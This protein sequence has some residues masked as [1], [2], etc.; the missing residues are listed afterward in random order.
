MDTELTVLH[1]YKD[2]F[3][4]LFR[5]AKKITSCLNIGDILEILRDEVKVTIP[6]AQEAC[7]IL[8]DSEAADYT[9]PL[10]CSV[11]KEQVNCQ[12]CKRGRAIVQKAMGEPLAFQCMLHDDTLG[13]MEFSGAC[14]PM[15]EVAIPIY[16][17]SEP[18]AV[19]NVV[20]ATGR[21][22]DEKDM[23]LLTDLVE[24]AG[25]IIINAKRY[26]KMAR[27]KLT[28]ERILG[29]IRTFVPDTVQ[30]IVEKNPDA[31]LLEK[32]EVDVSILFLDVADYTR[33]S[34]TLTQDKVNFIIEKYFSSFLDVIISYNGDVNETAGDGLMA[35]FQ[36]DAEEN[37]WNAACAALEI[38]RRTM[39]INKELEGL[40]YPVVVNMGINSGPSSLGM[41]KFAGGSGTRTTFTASGP[42]TNLAAR[43]AAAA[44][45]GEILIGPETA[46]RI[47]RCTMLF[48]RGLM[49]FKNITGNVHV[50]SLVP[51]EMPAD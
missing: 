48:D 27:E 13:P 24:L 45:E 46:R 49:T 43:I 44:R 25:N 22:L 28:V 32:R 37:A 19:L 16:E 41:S 21:L 7:L 38:R 31:P 26:S 10:H 12:N 18:L 33:I 5:V 36:G 23:I 20:T 30:K 40:F 29:H 14:G 11:K 17:G 3:E 6:H 47:E 51:S 1:L 9:R 34:E 39:Q 15:C 50:Y 4:N 42:V 35:I 8:V 2:R